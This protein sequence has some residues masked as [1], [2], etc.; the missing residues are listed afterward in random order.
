[1]NADV[2]RSQAEEAPI[3]S[4]TRS[5]RRHLDQAN[6]DQS[7][8]VR[9]RH[10]QTSQKAETP[11]PDIAEA[12][13]RLALAPDVGQAGQ[14]EG[15]LGIA[16]AVHNARRIDGAPLGI[17]VGAGAAVGLQAVVAPSVPQ[18]VSA[19][20][21]HGAVSR[22][23]G[24]FAGSKIR[25][26]ET[27]HERVEFFHHGGLTSDNADPTSRLRVDVNLPLATEA[28]RAAHPDILPGPRRMP[29][30]SIPHTISQRPMVRIGN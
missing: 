7:R 2:E 24:T 29:T 17:Q 27:P 18:N 5:R 4:R 20:T 25:T 8:D 22:M 16:A 28:F 19:Q 12:Q 23:A 21:D 3:A 26:M 30:R 6:D 10:G 9:Q 1:M 15:L 11:R 14:R 13:H